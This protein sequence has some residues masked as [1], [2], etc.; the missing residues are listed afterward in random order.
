MVHSMTFLL[1]DF[2]KSTI[3]MLSFHHA[4]HASMLPA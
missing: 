3:K 2:D 1:T 4:K